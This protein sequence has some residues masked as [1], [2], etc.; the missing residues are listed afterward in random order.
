MNITIVGGGK[1]G[2]YLVKT[3]LPYKH[4]IILVETDKEL[5]KKIANE[6]NVS[7]IRGNGT[8]IE[9]LNQIDGEEA[10]VFIAVTGKDEDNRISCQLAKRSFG[11]KRTIARVNNPKN[12]TVFEALGVDTAVSSTSVIAE[13]I[14]KE[15]DYSGVKTLMKLKKGNM[16]I[17]EIIISSKSP[18][19]GKMLK[20]I[21]LPKKC[22]IISVTRG[23]LALIPNGYTILEENDTIFSISSLEDQEELK[24]FFLG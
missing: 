11:V 22:V 20:D 10:D 7:V 16:V 4:K 12:I 13:L 8:N 14:E 23:E 6:L 24:T 17:S 2:Y 3:L 19:C 15:I 5:C 21:S 18:A 9:L 1:I